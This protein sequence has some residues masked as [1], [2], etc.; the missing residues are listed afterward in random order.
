MSRSPNAPTSPRLDSSIR[1][2][3]L[4]I[5]G[6]DHDASYLIETTPVTI[7]SSPQNSICLRHQ[8]VAA[9]HCEIRIDAGGA[10]LV[11]LE[12][13][14]CEVNGERVRERWLRPGDTIGVGAL[15]LQFQEASD[16]SSPPPS[17]ATLPS[18]ICD[19]DSSPEVHHLGFRRET[20][21]EVFL[22]E[23]R[24]APWMATSIAVHAL[25]LWI[26][27]EQPFWNRTPAPKAPV[28]QAGLSLEDPIEPLERVEMEP[29]EPE[30]T[31]EEPAFAEPELQSSLPDPIE[32]PKAD[33]ADLLGPE[34]MFGAGARSGALLGSGGDE[35]LRGSAGKAFGDRV[36]DLRQRGVEIVFVFDSTSSMANVIDDVKQSL[37]RMIT[38]LTWIVPHAR[39]GV[40]TFRDHGDDYV[41]RQ[42]PL[43]RSR[44]QILNWVDRIEAAGGGDVPEAVLEGLESAI[45]SMPWSER[46][47]QV[48]VLIGD[49]PPHSRTM[50]KI[51]E[52]VSRFHRS[53]RG[54]ADH[55]VS[56]IYTGDQ[57]SFGYEDGQAVE[58]LERIADKGG[59]QLIR[60]T[61]ANR[62]TRQCLSLAFGY[63]Y[64]ESIDRLFSDL[65]EGSRTQLLE[66]RLRRGSEKDI[67]WLLAKLHR[68]PV[69]PGIVRGLQV[70]HRQY[71]KIVQELTRNL[72]QEQVDDETRWASL[73]ILRRIFDFDF[74]YDPA[75]SPIDRERQVDSISTVIKASKSRP[76]RKR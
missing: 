51:D 19:A 20:F 6:S 1:R 24:R 41:V 73:Y 54:G 25:L 52:V 39:L 33:A 17:S 2:F 4:A 64:R 58:A 47:Q 74:D 38:I 50:R 40:V 71:P 36:T 60:L 72:Q 30:W 55:I 68:V 35:L 62:V 63:E 18:S 42:L 43:T 16:A 7:G 10:L 23:L 34:D 59:G 56:A 8:S 57:S 5:A 61:E 65:Q 32:L 53:A 48:I 76:R 11:N 46:S 15:S 28:L 13:S 3:R 14:G 26:L 29:L 75:A 44:Y 21:S 67:D 37:D 66:R 31:Q 70:Y 45:K 22:S 49:A 9:R 27:W 12:R 69:H